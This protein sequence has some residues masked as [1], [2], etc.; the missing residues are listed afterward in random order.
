MKY[1]IFALGVNS[2]SDFAPAHLESSLTEFVLNDRMT[3]ETIE[4]IHFPKIKESIVSQ[5]DQ[6]ANYDIDSYEKIPSGCNAVLVLAPE[7]ELER[8]TEVTKKLR[9]SGC[10][11]IRCG[12]IPVNHPAKSSS[13]S[14]KRKRNETVQRC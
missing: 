7:S 5:R 10:S 3:G 9:D 14:L 6:E 12:T 13:F 2:L 1:A 11:D 4:Y 8:L